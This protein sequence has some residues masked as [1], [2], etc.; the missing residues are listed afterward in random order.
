MAKRV[1]FKTR[2]GWVSFT[3]KK[4]PK[5]AKSSGAFEVLTVHDGGEKYVR[6]WTGSSEEAACKAA[7]SWAAKGYLAD[8]VK[9]KGKRKLFLRS[10]GG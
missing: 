9:R 1:R 7:R 10:F 3:K 5:R 8:V 4:K 2:D 6:R